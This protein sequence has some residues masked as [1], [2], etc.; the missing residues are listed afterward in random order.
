MKG[1]VLALFAAGMLAATPAFAADL[2]TKAPV[3]KAPFAV[4]FTWTGCYIGAQVGYG[5]ARG[6]HDFDNGAPSDVS[7]PRGVL[8]GGLLGCNYQI[9]TWVVGI[10]GDFE[11]ASLRDGDF[12]NLTGATS[13]GS[14]HMKWDGSV[15]GRLGYAMDRSLFYVTGGWAF[16]GFDFGGGP[17]STAFIGGGLPPCCGYSATVNGWTIGGGWEY[18]FTNNLSARIEYRHTDYRTASG[19]LQPIYPTVTMAVGVKTDVVR[20]GV[21]WKFLPM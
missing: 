18:A 19:F 1:R 4:P 8:G 3:Y 5:W 16:A 9:T 21:S 17:G 13:V 20:V 10:E 2:S 11:A 12:L 6:S 15:R 14:T 7:R